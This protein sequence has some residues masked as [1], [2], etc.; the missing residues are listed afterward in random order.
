MSPY[1]KTAEFWDQVFEDIETDFDY[2]ES[3]SIKEMEEGSDWL[4]SDGSSIIDFGSGTGKLLLRCLAKGAERGKGIDISSEAV[5]TSRELAKD[6]DVEE[7]TDFIVGGTET[8]STFDDDEFDAGILSNII[9][10]LEPEDARKV[11]DAFNRVIKSGGKILLKLND[12]LDPEQLD[13]AEKISENFYREETGLYFWNLKDD[14]A[15]ELLEDNFVI[16]NEL[17]IEFE[18]DGQVNRLYYLRN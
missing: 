3:L 5:R 14:E 16:E 17:K 12:H 18:E 13:S 9:D 1:E 6:N 7:K 10:N 8:L 4:I 11:L 15:R 2:R